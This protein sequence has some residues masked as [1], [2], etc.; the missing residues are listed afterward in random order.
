[1]WA[2]SRSAGLLFGGRGMA[3]GVRPT[4]TRRL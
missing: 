2:G 1:M 3:D 4:D